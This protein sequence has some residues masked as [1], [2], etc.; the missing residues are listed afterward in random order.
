MPTSR[1]SW[2][3]PSRW[4]RSDDLS[5]TLLR[6]SLTP[7]CSTPPQEPTTDQSEEQEP[8]DRFHQRHPPRS[9]SSDRSTVPAITPHRTQAIRPEGI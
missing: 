2:V 1:R 8:G 3:L 9:H 6:L 7:P 4:Q 5:H